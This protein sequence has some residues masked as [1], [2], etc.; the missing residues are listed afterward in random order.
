MKGSNTR[1][2]ISGWD[3]AAIIA[4]LQLQIAAFAFAHID[5][6]MA[7]IGG[8]LDG[9]AHEV[10]QQALK[11]HGIAADDDRL[12]AGA[13][14]EL[15]RRTSRHLTGHRQ[16]TIQHLVDVDRFL[17]QLQLLGFKGGR[18]QKVGDQRQQKSLLSKI[19]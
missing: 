5:R 14:R 16:N 11:T 12:I 7:V 10:E 17:D 2:I 9:I 19:S 18:L 6:N 8:E 3:A 4:H 1:P 13:E 15:P